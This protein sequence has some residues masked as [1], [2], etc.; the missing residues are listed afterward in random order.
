MTSPRL[1]GRGYSTNASGIAHFSSQSYSFAINILIRV[2]Q[3][4]VFS[5]SVIG[6]MIISGV[7]FIE[8]VDDSVLNE[9][10]YHVFN[11]IKWTK[12]ATRWTI[13]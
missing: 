7:L 4:A 10:G 1:P 6:F 9:E 2:I 5:I 13:D 11:S 3:I 12:S 8:D